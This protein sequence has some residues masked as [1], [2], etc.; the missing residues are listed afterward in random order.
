MVAPFVSCTVP[1]L[2]H[3]ALPLLSAAAQHGHDQGTEAISRP[4]PVAGVF[5]T[6]P[7]SASLP[8][9][10]DDT[11]DPRGG[12]RR[13]KRGAGDFRGAATGLTADFGETDREGVADSAQ[14]QAA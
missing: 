8:S 11:R 13:C 5:R 4:G 10:G 3:E 7:S 2:R 6:G 1:T 14:G 9:S 12:L